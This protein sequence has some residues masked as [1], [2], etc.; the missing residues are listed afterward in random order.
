MPL[1]LRENT[2]DQVVLVQP[3]HD[4][5][6]GAVPLV[7][8]PAVESMDEPLV[9]GLP[10]C[11]RERLVR[12]QRIVNQDYVGAA[13][14]EHT[15]G[16]GGEP[17]ALAGGDEL[18]HRLAVQRQAGWKELTIPRAHH[19]A[20][21]IAGELIGELLGIADAED[22]R[23]GIMPQTPGREGDRGHQGFQM[24]GWQ[25]DDLL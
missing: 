14:G 25:V 5:D 9:A 22:L 20:A 18:L 15:T 8:E 1:L 23:R 2:A 17:V 16:R 10:L 21:A 6:D 13:T 24:T 12:L 19:D 4:D 3:L 7:V 11:V